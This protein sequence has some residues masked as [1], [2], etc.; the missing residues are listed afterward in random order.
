[1]SYHQIFSLLILNS[2]LGLF[3]K[4][5]IIFFSIQSNFPHIQVITFQLADHLFQFAILEGFFHDLIPKNTIQKK[6][7]KNFNEREF[8]EEVDYL[9][10][11]EILNLNLN[12]P[13]RSIQNLVNGINFLLDEFAPPE[14][15]KT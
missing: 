2:Q 11:L 3:L 9:N 4:P 7:F 10:V 14:I 6:D 12:D 1:M 8:L 5:S 13:N 15:E